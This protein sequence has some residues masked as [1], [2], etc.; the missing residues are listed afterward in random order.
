MTKS[1][2][3][4]RSEPGCRQIY[5]NVGLVA[6]IWTLVLCAALTWSARAQ[7]QNDLLTF[8]YSNLLDGTLQ[9]E[10]GFS[11]YEMVLAVEEALGL[12]AQY[13]PL[14]FTELED[15]GIPAA[16]NPYVGAGLPQIRIGHHEIDGNTLAHAYSPGSNGLSYDVHMDSSNRTWDEQFFL[17]AV[18]HELGHSIGID[19]HI[20]GVTAVMNAS[21]GAAN[22]NL[23]PAIG[24]GFL[25]QADIEAAQAIW[26]VGSGQVVTQ[27]VWTGA[28]SNS[29]SSHNNWE[30]GWRPSPASNVF[31]QDDAMTT[32]S[33]AQAIRSLTMGGGTN[34]LEIAARGSVTVGQDVVLGTLDGGKELVAEGSA[35][36]TLVPTNADLDDQWLAIDFDDEGW[37]QGE[38][39]VGFDVER[40]Y[41]PFIG[42]D[43]RAV[44]QNRNASLYTRIEFD[45]ENAS[46][47]EF[48]ALRMR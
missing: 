29:W 44:M 42:T 38:T 11:Q 40:D 6:V 26:G 33:E 48:L 43:V 7:A 20:E 17:T 1:D 24:Q 13:L 19:D 3:V 21:L 37:I 47:L 28:D 32:V 22:G 36:R 25:F 27:R 10:N 8:G 2:G 45:L 18:T 39:G 46:D 15:D 12:W 5:S 41:R 35:A 9:Q 4:N 14:D 34:R 16:D 30:Q 31:I 23:L